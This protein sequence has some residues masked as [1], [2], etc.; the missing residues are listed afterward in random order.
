MFASVSIKEPLEEILR[1]VSGCWGPEGR[2]VPLI[3]ICIKYGNYVP[4]FLNKTLRYLVMNRLSLLNNSQR[5]NEAGIQPY[6]Q[7]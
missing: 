1:C 5:M 7:L 2:Q 4:N 3:L 6:D